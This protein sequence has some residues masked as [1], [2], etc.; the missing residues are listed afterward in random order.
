MCL[1]GQE[2]LVYIGGWCIYVPVQHIYTRVRLYTSMWW[3]RASVHFAFSL[4]QPPLP[5]G[6][7]FNRLQVLEQ[8]GYSTEQSDLPMPAA[9]LAKYTQ[10]GA[11]TDWPS[12]SL[13][14]KAWLNRQGQMDEELW[15]P[16]TL[17]RLCAKHWI[18][19]TD[20][21]QR[22]GAGG[23]HTGLER[24]GYSLGQLG[25]LLPIN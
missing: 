14:Q 4:P 23:D 21:M 17:H 9:K 8:S 11:S 20:H 10:F 25:P 5:K 1:S 13:R 2:T 16:V 18:E 6:S 15:R 22:H 3:V 12:M 24:N 7:I 19:S